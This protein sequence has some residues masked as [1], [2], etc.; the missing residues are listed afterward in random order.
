MRLTVAICTRNRAASLERTLAS[1]VQCAPPEVPWEVV[2]V[3]NGSR[4][5]TST[6]LTRFAGRLP[7]R[8]I[9]ED[10][11]G[12]SRARNAAVR[13]ARGEY[14]VWTDDDC[15]VDQRWL[16]EYAAAFNQ[17]PDAA[18]FGGPIRPSF[19]DGPPAWLARTATRVASAFAARDLGPTPITLSTEQNRLPYGANYA[20][21]AHEQ[22]S[23]L[24][25]EDLGRGSFLATLGE[26]SVLMEDL[27]RQGAV[28]RWVPNAGVTHCIPP[29]RQRLS[30]LREYYEAYGALLEWRNQTGRHSEDSRDSSSRVSLLKRRLYHGLRFRML[31]PI[32]SEERW[33]D[34]F[35]AGAIAHGRSKAR[36][37]PS[38]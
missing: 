6:V 37:E 7:L 1:L 21:R 4:D 13:V 23:R 35:I 14:I 32:V 9:I 36:R 22:R 8:A 17:W 16:I 38:G 12:L 33:I 5:T 11:P 31:R 25:D 34:D 10:T 28:G 24:Y 2:V 26:E 30:Y 18:V 3:D 27:L 19:I 20:I 29:E 15:V